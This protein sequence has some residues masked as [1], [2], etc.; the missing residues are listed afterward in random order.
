MKRAAFILICLIIFS[1]TDNQEKKFTLDPSKSIEI[2]ITSLDMSSEGNYNFNIYMIN[3]QPVSGIQLELKPTKTY[4]VDSVSTIGQRITKDDDFSI[5]NNDS[6]TIL[7]FSMSGNKIDESDTYD[8]NRNSILRVFT[9]LIDKNIALPP[10][11]IWAQS[12]IAN[13]KGKKIESTSIA[14]QLGK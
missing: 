9:K 3:H 6:G 13:A 4:T 2:G 1:C 14:Y 7:L 12:I 5:H 8:K 11:S 10:D